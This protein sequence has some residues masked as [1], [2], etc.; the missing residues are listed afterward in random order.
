MSKYK[1]R[2]IKKYDMYMEDIS[3]Y[4]GFTLFVF[5]R[6]VVDF[7]EVFWKKFKFMFF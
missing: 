4:F 5:D 2:K 7:S 6:S 3:Y 1:K